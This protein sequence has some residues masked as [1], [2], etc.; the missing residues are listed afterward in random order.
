MAHSGSH[1]NAGGQVAIAIQAR[2]ICENPDAGPGGVGV[3]DDGLAYTLEAQTTPQAVAFPLDTQNMSR[4]STTPSSSLGFG[5]DGDPSF[6]LG[7]G[8]H[9][10]VAFDLRGREG[11]AHEVAGT[12]KSMNT[13]GGFSNSIEHAAGGY[14]A[15]SQT[16]VAA[17]DPRNVTSQANRTRVEFGAPC[18]TLHEKG[19]S[20]IEQ[21]LSAW[22]VRRLT[23]RECERLQGFPDDYTLVE[24]RKKPA[25]DGPRYKALGNSMAV[26]V[27]R[28]IGTRIQLVDDL[29]DV[30]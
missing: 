18:N 27:M 19:L 3:R 10:A 29:L 24:Y 13:S 16:H 14:M 28:W 22:A 20:V 6:T 17:F 25:A 4:T 11:G 8:H 7:A 26:P 21:N 30:L 23:P 9:H 5:Q 15:L 12:M 2:A 1:A